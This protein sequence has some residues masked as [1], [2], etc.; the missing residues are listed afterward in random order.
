MWL[1][2][3]SGNS[4]LK[5]FFTSTRTTY[6]PVTI[7]VA[8]AKAKNKKLRPIVIR[9]KVFSIPRRAE[10]TPPVSAP[11]NPPS[12]APLLCRITLAIRATEVMINPIFKYVDT[13]TSWISEKEKNTFTTNLIQNLQNSVFKQGDYTFITG[14]TS[15]SSSAGRYFPW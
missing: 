12:P 8:I 6:Q 13:N 5:G 3:L 10:N 1:A 4:I 11:V 15:R 2:T 9:N 7:T 14:G